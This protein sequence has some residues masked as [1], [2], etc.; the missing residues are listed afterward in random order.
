[1]VLATSVSPMAPI[2]LLS[3]HCTTLTKGNM[4][5]LPDIGT[6]GESQCTTVG[7]R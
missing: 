4:Y 5:S 1:M 7:R 6:S 2:L 3:G